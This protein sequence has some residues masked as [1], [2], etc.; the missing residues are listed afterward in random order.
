[1]LRYIIH[2]L[3]RLKF[4]NNQSGFIPVQ[5]LLVNLSCLSLSKLLLTN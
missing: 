4:Q 3:T 1:M 2:A 5:L